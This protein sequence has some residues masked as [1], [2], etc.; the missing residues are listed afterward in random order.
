MVFNANLLH[1][2]GA[3]SGSTVT[4]RPPVQGCCKVPIHAL[5]LVKRARRSARSESRQRSWRRQAD[6]HIA[7]T[8]EPSTARHAGGPPDRWLGWSDS[9]SCLPSLQVRPRNADFAMAL[10]AALPQFGGQL[11][12]QPG[13][14][15]LLDVGQG[16]RVDAR[17]A[18]IAAHRDPR[19]LQNVSAVDLVPKR[20]KSTSG[21]GLGRPVE[22]VLQGSN[23]IGRSRSR[24]GGTSRNGTHR[25]PPSHHDAS[26]KQRP[27]PH[28]RLCC[29]LGSIGT[30]AASDA[31]PAGRPLPE[32]IGYRTPRSDNIFRRLPGQGGP[33]Q[34]PPP[35]SE[36]S[37]PHTPGSSSRLQSRSYTASLAF[38]PISKGSALPGAALAGG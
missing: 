17:C 6:R 7:L 16:G 36:R 2:W 10:V 5:D 11:I 23:R 9:A 27:F 22:R 15:V 20:M 25:A 31:L 29:P 32:V 3:V 18:V 12:E 33:P 30:T 8:S 4:R 26:T 38:T 37:A 14:P 1:G 21:I 28:R 35:L 19:A 34:F 24:S 13:N